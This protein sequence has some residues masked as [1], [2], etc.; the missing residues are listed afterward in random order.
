[1]PTH[2]FSQQDLDKLA[3]EA[4]TL[5]EL[6][7]AQ[8]L[9]WGFVRVQSNL[10]DELPLLLERLSQIGHEL[11]AHAQA[12]GIGSQDILDNLRERKL[13][14]DQRG[15]YRS[16]FAE[17]VRL[18]FLLRQVLP[19]LPWNEAPR[20]VS[21]MRLH[22]QRRRYPRRDVPASELVAA[23]E[24]MDADDLERSVITTLLRGTDGS[25][26]D[27]A[28]FQKEA[29]LQQLRFL[30]ERGD[31]A[32]VIGAGTGAGKTKAFYIPALAHI[33]SL[34]GEP[35]TKAIA[36]YPR[37]ELL[38]DQLLE[39]WSEARKL[40][41]LLSARQLRPV[42][43]GA[44]YA[45]TPRSAQALIENDKR[46]S[47]FQ[48]WNQTAVKDGWIFPSMP[49]PTCRHE[50]VWYREDVVAEA[51]ANQKGHYGR[52]ARLRCSSCKLEVGEGQIALTREQMIKHPPDLL[53]T[54]TETL[55]RRLSRSTEHALFGIGVRRPPRLLLLDE[56]H[57]YEGMSG[58]QVA[59]LL[60][61]WRHAR[62]RH[63]GQGLLIVGLSAT[64]AQ[65][66]RF[67]ARLTG[68]P[69]EQVQYIMP[70]EADLI[71]EGVEYN[72]ILKGDP[73][74]GTSLLSTSVQTAMLLA[75]MLDP[76][77]S[78]EQDTVSR[79]AF[80]QKIF[81][82][83]D[84]LDVINRWFHIE[85]D[86]EVNQVLSSLR[87]RPRQA[88]N[89]EMQRRQEAGQWWWACEQI[90][91][92]LEAPLILDLT[93]SQ[94][95]GVRAE[96]N[97][98]LATSTLEVGFNDPLVGAVIQ[99]KAPR[100]MASFLQRKGRAGRT[101]SMRPWMVVVISAYGRDRWA[102]QHAEN[103]FSPTLPPIELPLE[104]VYVRK[105][106]A[107]YTLMDWLAATLAHKGKRVDIWA[108]FSSDERNRQK[109]GVQETRRS[110]CALLKEVLTGGE[111]LNGLQT[112]L[113]AALGLH[114]DEYALNAILW[115]E[116]RPLLL[117]VI[118]TLLR[119]LESDW[120]RV[121]AGVVVTWSDSI[122]PNP[123]P[124]F[125]S[126]TLF[127]LMSLPELQLHIPDS[128]APHA[129]LRDDQFMELVQG[130]GEFAPG[131]VSKRYA[132]SHLLKEAHWLPLP[133]EALIDGSVAQLQGLAIEYDPTPRRVTIDEVE[134]LLYPPRAY[135]L[136]II[137]PTVLPTSS[138]RLF[139]R[140]RFEPQN[141]GAISGDE[142]PSRMLSLA[143]NS[144]WRQV[145][146]ELRAYTLSS[147]S[148]VEVTRAAVGVRAETRYS[149]GTERRRRLRFA[150]GEQPAALGFSLCVDA[151][152]VRFTL[153][154]TSRLIAT[155]AWP[156]LR[157][158]LVPAYLLYRLEQDPRLVARELSEFEVGWLWQ[159]ETS[160][161]MAV[162]V[163]R[164]VTLE[165]AAEEV[166]S[167]RLALAEHTMD[168]IFQ[169]QRIDEEDDLD[170]TG[171]LRDRLTQL[172][173]TPEVATVLAEC[174]TVLWA[175]PDSDLMAWLQQ[176]YAASLGATLLDAL[177]KLAPDINPDDLTMDVEGDTI[178]IA[179]Q[180]P[181]G[182]GLIER[183]VE[184][185]HRRPRDLD[186]QLLDSIRH[187]DRELL[188][189]QLASVTA[190]MAENEPQLA[191]AFATA[192]TST[193]MRGSTQTLRDLMA[194]LEGQGIAATREL[195]V[196][197]N[198]RIL[199]PSSDT[200]SDTLIAALTS[201]WAVEQGR[202]ACA[203]DPRVMA[204]AARNIPEI[205]EQVQAVL[206]RIGGP[207]A[208]IGESQ[209]FNL[210]QSL[211]WLEC[212]DSCPD[213]IDQGQPYQRMAK[214]SRTLL[215]A[216]I[217]PEDDLVVY[218]VA[219][220]QERVLAL[221]GERHTAQVICQ[222]AE[223]GV[224]RVE[225]AHLLA[226]LVEVGFQQHYPTLEQLERRGQHWLASLV[227][228][229][230]IQS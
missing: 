4:L 201:R 207:E 30:R 167:N 189:D 35:W 140:S 121:E 119:Q 162:A 125:I 134:L 171:R 182:V 230:L 215:R 160:M 10:A 179:E 225:F 188:A 66:E 216:L 175:A 64:L 154:D 81:A 32:L 38:K 209:I 54:T 43:V 95:R 187:C 36:I 5:I 47:R 127:S 60:R 155:T 109:S 142:A 194:A 174:A 20:L 107:A 74:S 131:H 108:A 206:R 217:D 123:M 51:A 186:Q 183:M 98:V 227:I 11:W 96:A 99:H 101:R 2:S 141:R 21:D 24:Q 3:N 128:L 53:F 58:A 97:L 137:P 165:L 100:S 63:P 25:A 200:D 222:Q 212:R 213:C 52:F 22:L 111:A 18:L 136:A 45:D 176:C 164:N 135:R 159:L 69:T 181:G 219:G 211:L 31:R 184:A 157:Q 229:D 185:I 90:G 144:P 177:S 91:H 15:R 14:F 17:A 82:F 114:G 1:M 117:E 59:Y 190:L 132:R 115:G 13:L 68:L 204:V 153:L 112:H 9:S 124:H 191:A 130:M 65:A 151:I 214:P 83:T 34:V 77:A 110:I 42:T 93:S 208:A 113:D 86:A 71:E 106:Q 72:L 104:N 168:V 218:G 39:A 226:T 102:F 220:W 85:Q 16:R 169:S 62:G 79:G 61:R 116:P 149:N 199:R 156:R 44:Y 26:F 118:P 28:R 172:I 27:L 152:A 180:T 129:P 76:A 46:R 202:L 120:Q 49:C 92:D 147:G 56:I 228:R 87:M 75:R 145:L 223:V 126:P 210:L 197:I 89:D 73:V 161:L 105:M 170:R 8:L 55:N 23:L 80:G 48:L 70:A 221:L 203:I 139:W 150:Q 29:V 37:V 166:A 40:D 195:I 41:A 78:R 84:T 7:E 94:Y 88:A 6:A 146:S 122:S 19:W 178:W 158:S 163:A 148:W 12:E 33:A 193:D 173:A 57:T 224:L 143:P 205:E 103:L 198:T 67:F 196:A 192:R 138:A 133:D 50:L